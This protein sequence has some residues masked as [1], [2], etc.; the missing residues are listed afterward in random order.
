MTLAEGTAS[1]L[2]GQ[3]ERPPIAEESKRFLEAEL[4]QSGS[5]IMTLLA[6]ISWQTD[7]GREE[8]QEGDGEMDKVGVRQAGG[9]GGDRPVCNVEGLNTEQ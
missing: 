8:E 5:K 6:V 2:V 9:L 1:W 7:R 3:S 4:E